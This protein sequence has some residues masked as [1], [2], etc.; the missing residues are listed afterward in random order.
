MVYWSYTYYL[1]GTVVGPNPFLYSW[2]VA[3]WLM[4]SF[5]IL[6]RLKDVHLISFYDKTLLLICYHTC[7]VFYYISFHKTSDIWSFINFVLTCLF[8]F[9][10]FYGN[11]DFYIRKL[12]ST[13]QKNESIFWSTLFLLHIFLFHCQI[14][15]KVGSLDMGY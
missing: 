13:M 7:Y 1:H 15:V 6:D 5:H 11:K 10:Y 8:I 3:N 4:G 12:Y 14:Q 9:K 2:Q